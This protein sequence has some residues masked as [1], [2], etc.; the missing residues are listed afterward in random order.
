MFAAKYDPDGDLVW[1]T[2]G[3]GTA[4]DRGHDITTDAEG[5]GCITGYFTAAATFGEG[6]GSV[7]VTGSGWHDAFV[8]KYDSAGLPSWVEKVDGT[9]VDWGVYVA[10]GPNGECVVTG[11][12]GGTATFSSASCSAEL[13]T[14]YDHEIFIAK[15]DDSVG[16]CAPW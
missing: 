6:A 5:N 16:I 1:A 12:F 2:S 4:E 14:V 8:A 9:N 13:T 10:T 15:Y 7:T 11:E 3:G